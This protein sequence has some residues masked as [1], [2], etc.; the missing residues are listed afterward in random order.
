MIGQNRQL[1]SLARILG[2][3]ALLTACSSEEPSEP[4][5][6]LES[7]QNDP[8]AVERGR[9]LFEGSCANYCHGTEPRPGEDVDLFDCQWR[10]G[11]SNEDIFRIVSSGIPDTRMVGF[12]NNFPEGQNDLWKIIAYLRTQQQ[13]C[14]Q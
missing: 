8:I 14:E 2:V 13:S 6:L 7:F 12:G 1:A 5:S 10:H 4:P 9:M 11:G 3:L